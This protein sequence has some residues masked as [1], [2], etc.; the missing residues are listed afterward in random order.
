MTF[1][2]LISEVMKSAS[3]FG[4]LMVG[5][6]IPGTFELCK[7]GAALFVLCIIT[8]IAPAN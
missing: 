3:L 6:L 4:K 5:I 1:P 2:L 8:P 7:S